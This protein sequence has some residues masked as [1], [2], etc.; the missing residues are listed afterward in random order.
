MAKLRPHVR[1]RDLSFSL[2]SLG[3]VLS[4]AACSSG[5][6]F[7]ED[8]ASA[9]DAGLTESVAT[10]ESSALPNEGGQAQVRRRQ[11]AARTPRRT[12]HSRTPQIA[13]APFQSSD[14]RWLN[15]FYFVRSSEETWKSVS[16]KI[17]GRPDRAEFLK[18]WN[19]DRGLA[20][21]EVVYYNSPSRPE[22][23][24]DMKVFAQDFGMELESHTVQ[25]DDWMSKIGHAR[26]GDVRTWREIAALNPDISNPDLIEIGQVLRVQPVHIDTAAAL[27]KIIAQLNAEAAQAQTAEAAEVPTPKADDQ[28]AAANATGTLQTPTE[29]QP[30]FF[31]EPSLSQLEQEPVAEAPPPQKKERPQEKLSAGPPD[32]LVIVGGLVVGLLLAILVLRRVRARKAFE[33]AVN[34][35]TEITRSKTAS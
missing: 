2:V 3:T 5:Q 8:Q 33:Q 20:P 24:R 12:A 25:L 23:S 31:D 32:T 30:L 19:S 15:A 14:G 7:R 10:P 27:Q 1:L 4:I 26:F 22:D 6:D 35:V 34:N 16:Q 28:V 11:Q 29:S 17:Y 21:G 13:A 18:S 9:N